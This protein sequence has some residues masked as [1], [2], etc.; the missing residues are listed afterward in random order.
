MVTRMTMRIAI[1]N[2][3]RYS[4]TI[5]TLTATQLALTDAS[6]VFEGATADAHETTLTVTDPTADRTIT[7]PNV[8]GTIVTT[9]DTGSVTNTMLAGSIA[10]NKLVNYSVSFGGISLDLGQSDATPAFDLADATNYPTSSL[11]GTIT[12]AQISNSNSISKLLSCLS[13]T[14]S[15]FRF[16]VI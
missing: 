14:E 9:G 10:N 6:I 16:R 11:V 4:P 8:T 15:R 7:V 2:A 1:P 5:T 3:P 13:Y 12:N